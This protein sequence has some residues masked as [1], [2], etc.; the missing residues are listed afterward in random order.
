[1]IVESDVRART[2]FIPTTGQRRLQLYKVT[3]L[4]DSFKVNAVRRRFDARRATLSTLK[5]SRGLAPAVRALRSA[6]SVEDGNLRARG[7]R[8]RVSYI[9]VTPIVRASGRVA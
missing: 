5:G 8:E 3:A 4:H 6:S 1:V 2:T 9:G 7:A